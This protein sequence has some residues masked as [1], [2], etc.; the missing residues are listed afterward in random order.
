MTTLTRKQRE[1]ENRKKL[2]LKKSRDLFLRHGYA[3]VSIQDICTA[4]EYGKSAI[5]SHFKSKDEIYAHIKL[6]AIRLLADLLEEG[7]NPRAKSRDK[8]FLKCARLLFDYYAENTAYYKAL[9]LSHH[10][11]DNV[12]K[13]SVYDQILAEKERARAP[14]TGLLETGMAEG[15][16]RRDDVQRL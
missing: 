1:L 15:E 2:I 16:F 12:D 8:E 5:Y 11:E 4:V 14:M 7:V 9:F 10:D 6:E 3:Q 13:S